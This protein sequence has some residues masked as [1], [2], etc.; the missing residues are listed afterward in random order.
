[1]CLQLAQARLSMLR[2][3][4][5]CALQSYVLSLWYT[6]NFL[7]S[8]LKNSK[9]PKNMQHNVALHWSQLYLLKQKRSLEKKVDL[10]KSNKWPLHIYYGQS[11]F[12]LLNQKE[13][14]IST[15]H[16]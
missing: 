15:Q 14:S 2:L 12:N 3:G 9:T 7:K 10:K 6:S 8:N 16:G 1:M 13:W 11:N 5:G 4:K